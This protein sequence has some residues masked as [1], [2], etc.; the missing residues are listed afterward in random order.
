MVTRH[1]FGMFNN[2]YCKQWSRFLGL[3]KGVT[4]FANRDF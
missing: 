4:Q 1:A 2:C 3:A